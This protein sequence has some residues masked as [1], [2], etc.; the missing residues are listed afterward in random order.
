MKYDND[1]IMILDRTF[2]NTLLLLIHALDF[3][4]QLTV[5][6]ENL[7]DTRIHLEDLR[8]MFFKGYVHDTRGDN[9]QARAAFAKRVSGGIISVAFPPG[10]I[11]LTLAPMRLS[12]HRSLTSPSR[13]EER[14]AGRFRFVGATRGEI[15]YAAAALARW[16]TRA[17]PSRAVAGCCCASMLSTTNLCS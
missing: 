10:Q 12:R 14:R 6:R 15:R 11:T 16:Q 17:R 1:M 5:T 8:R 9:H 3:F 13:M 7:Y 2:C 4:L